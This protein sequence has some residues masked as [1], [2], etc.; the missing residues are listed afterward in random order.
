MEKTGSFQTKRVH[1]RLELRSLPSQSTLV[2]GG[3]CLKTTTGRA[4]GE[5]LTKD[6]GAMKSEDTLMPGTAAFSTKTVTS[7]KPCRLS[8][9]GKEMM[10]SRLLGEE[11][12]E[13]RRPGQFEPSSCDLRTLTVFHGRQDPNLCLSGRVLGTILSKKYLAPLGHFIL[14]QS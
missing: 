1:H 3:L 5:F 4:W 13:G 7:M 14:V 6:E 8:P 11:A 9:P 2:G 10:V 12:K